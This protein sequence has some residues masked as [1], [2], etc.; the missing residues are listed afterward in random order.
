MLLLGCQNCKGRTRAGASFILSENEVGIMNELKQSKDLN[1]ILADY[2]DILDVK[3]I[4]AILRVCDKTVCNLIRDGTLRYI[5]IGRAYRI[6]KIYL[7]EL[8]LGETN[9]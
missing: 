8:L 9:L 1:V 4:G 5:R 6:P 7:T 2:P 3:Q